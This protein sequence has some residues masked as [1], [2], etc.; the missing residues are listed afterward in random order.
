MREIPSGWL[1]RYLH[2]NVSSFLFILLFMHIAIVIYFVS[3]R[4]P[5]QLVWC[6]GV[7]LFILIS[8]IAF[9]VYTLPWGQISFLGSTV[10]TNLITAIP[11][12]GQKIVLWLLGSFAI[13]QST[14]NRFF[15]LHYILSILALGLAIAHLILLHL[16]GSTTPVFNET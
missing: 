3:F 5:K 1:L 10:I 6:S 4:K 14:L 7:I 11:I 15:S 8:G 16:V 2:S 9:L 13:S 12:I